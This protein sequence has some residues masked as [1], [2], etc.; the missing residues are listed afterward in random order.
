MDDGGRGLQWRID[1][2]GVDLKVVWE[3]AA[4][5]RPTAAAQYARE[6]G[7]TTTSG[8]ETRVKHAEADDRSDRSCGH[9]SGVCEG[10]GVELTRHTLLI[11]Y[12]II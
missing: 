12:T 3:G 10:G 5:T 11:I 6:A 2:N 9:T 7:A 8:E 4:P 1:E